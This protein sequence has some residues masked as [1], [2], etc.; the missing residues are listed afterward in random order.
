M[1]AGFVMAPS[2]II[3]DAGTRRTQQMLDLFTK[4]TCAIHE[5]MRPLHAPAGVIWALNNTQPDGYTVVG[6]KYRC[7]WT[8]GHYDYNRWRVKPCRDT[9]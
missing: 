5:T 3:V 8:K 7:L 6:S 2:T 9:N 4:D 1:A